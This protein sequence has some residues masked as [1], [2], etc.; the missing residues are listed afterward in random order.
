MERLD[1]FMARSNALYY[2]TH[3][4]FQDF[5]TA[6]EISQVFGE[7]LGAWAA[8]VWRTMG[9]PSPVWLAEIGPGRGTLMQ[10]ALRAIGRVAPGFAAA[11]SVHLVETSPRLRRLQGQL[12]AGTWHD[13]VETLPAGPLILLANE[14]LDA[15]PIRQFVRRGTAWAERWVDAGHIVEQPAPA[16]GRD[17]DDGAVVEIGEV[18]AS[19]VAAVAARLAQSRGAALFLDYGATAGGGD[20]LQAIRAG[21]PADPFAQLGEADLTAHVDFGALAGVAAASGA[22]VHGPLPQ[23][24]FL[25]R[26]G[27]HQRSF[28]LAQ[29]QSP[30]RAKTLLDAASRLAEPV[31]MGRLFKAFALTHPALPV[32]PGF[33]E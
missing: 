21:R 4:P 7:L 26:L 27:L 32:P 22:A 6:P 11:L 16:P 17:A 28:R 15:L 29:T 24:V 12:V 9:E 1:G 33:T 13:R 20:T 18:A 19:V 14:F 23:G 30:G 3:D 5:T 31:H 25:N 8:V 10:D 2:E